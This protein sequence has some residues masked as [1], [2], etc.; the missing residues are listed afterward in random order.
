MD[1]FQ[2]FLVIERFLVETT[3]HGGGGG[4][5]LADERLLA[6]GIC[7]LYVREVLFFCYGFLFYHLRCNVGS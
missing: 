6:F 5:G 4:G 2:L 1:N 3:L 7:S